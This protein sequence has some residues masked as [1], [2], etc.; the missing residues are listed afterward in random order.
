MRNPFNMDNLLA[1]ISQAEKVVQKGS[2]IHLFWSYDSPAVL[3]KRHG[4]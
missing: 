1:V 4:N 3:W 2:G